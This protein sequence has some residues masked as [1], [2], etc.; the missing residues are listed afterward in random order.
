[1]LVKL[2]WW[3]VAEQPPSIMA[4]GLVEVL[5]GGRGKEL[6][7]KVDLLLYASCIYEPYLSE[8]IMFYFFMD[9]M[10]SM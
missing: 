5:A 2:Q 7:R 9:K 6:W 10:S 4:N 3:L 8:G 1:M